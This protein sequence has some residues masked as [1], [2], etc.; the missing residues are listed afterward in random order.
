MNYRPAVALTI[1]GNTLTG[2]FRE[3]KTGSKGYNFNGKVML[4]GE[5]YQFSGNLIKVHSKG[6][7]VEEFTITKE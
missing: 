7:S 2:G 6:E 5:K 4:D 3:F 1:D